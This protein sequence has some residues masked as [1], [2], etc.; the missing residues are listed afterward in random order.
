MLRADLSA[1]GVPF[2]DEAGH[3]YDFHALRHQFITDMVR[4]GVHPKDA[5]ALARHSTIDLTMNRYAHVRKADLAAALAKL[6]PVA[7]AGATGPEERR[8]A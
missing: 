8:Q 1:A 2:E 6:P 3:V 5:Q 4:A 7:A